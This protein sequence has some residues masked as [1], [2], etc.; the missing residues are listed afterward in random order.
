MA[1]HWKEKPKTVEADIEND[2]IETVKEYM[3]EQDDRTRAAMIGKANAASPVLY[4]RALDKRGISFEAGA[5]RRRVPGE[6]LVERRG[7]VVGSPDD[8]LHTTQPGVQV[9]TMST[10]EEIAIADIGMYPDNLAGV[11][12]G[13]PMAWEDAN[14]GKGNP[15]FLKAQ[16]YRENCQ[17]CVVVHEARRRGYD[18]QAL[19]NDDVLGSIPQRLAKETNIAWVNPKTGEHPDYVTLNFTKRKEY[20]DFLN[21]EVGINQRYTFEFNWK[22]VGGGHIVSVD[23]TDG[24]LLRFYDPQSGKAHIGNH[25]V[26]KYL[27]KIDIEA[28]TSL[29]LRVDNMHFNGEVAN[30]VLKGTIN[31]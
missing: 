2:A 8:G 17:I 24:G 4:Q 12:R 23:R 18:V 20:V 26:A 16:G 31:G 10:A 29:L 19:A 28:M 22:D 1:G 3:N 5:T 15:N 9:A 6:L 11:K 25:A 7:S 14:K 27:K 13:A 30:Q 21:I